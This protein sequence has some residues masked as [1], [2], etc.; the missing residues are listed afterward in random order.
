[1]TSVF[2]CAWEREKKWELGLIYLQ[3]C[4]SI[5]RIIVCKLKWKSDR[6]VSWD[7]KWVSYLVVPE[8]YMLLTLYM[9]NKLDGFIISY[10]KLFQEVNIIATVSCIWFYLKRGL[11]FYMWEISQ[12]IIVMSTINNCSASWLWTAGQ[13]VKD[14]KGNHFKLIWV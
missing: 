3:Y 10:N 11:K 5:S 7:N 14:G 9:W 12:L 8:I 6:I 4:I 2:L 1:M 13:R